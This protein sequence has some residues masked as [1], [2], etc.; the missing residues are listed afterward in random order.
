MIMDGEKE[1]TL[2]IRGEDLPN[3]NLEEQVEKGEYK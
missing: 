3:L 1:R 2:D